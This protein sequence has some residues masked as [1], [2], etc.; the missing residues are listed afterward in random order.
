MR[1]ADADVLLGEGCALGWEERS[2][3]SLG[4]C[5]H[6]VEVTERGPESRAAYVVDVPTGETYLGELEDG[7]LVEFGPAEVVD[8]HRGRHEMGGIFDWVKK[9]FLPPPPL[10]PESRALVPAAPQPMIPSPEERKGLLAPIRKF[11][12][13]L[14][15]PSGAS[16]FEAFRPK[17]QLPVEAQESIPASY[18][19]PASMFS[20]FDPSAPGPLSRFAEHAG[21]IAV[22][23]VPGP[24]APFV[25]RAQEVF[26]PFQASPEP[27]PFEAAQARQQ[28]LWS[29]MFSEQAPVAEA[30]DIFKP[31]DKSEVVSYKQ[32]IRDFPVPKGYSHKDVKILRLPPRE[33]LFPEVEDVARGLLEFYDP[34]D[35]KLF[36]YIRDT[37][38]EDWW[39]GTVEED[40]ISVLHLES[41]GNCGDWPDVLTEVAAFLNIPWMALRSLAEVAEDEE[42]SEEWEDVS[43]VYDNIVYPA[44]DLIAKAANLLKPADLPGHFEVSWD[45]DHGCML[46][47]NYVETAPG[48]DRRR[49]EEHKHYPE[50]HGGGEEG[51][52]DEEIPEEEEPKPEPV[53]KPKKKKK[54]AGKKR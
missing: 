33:E 46:I 4:D 32:A 27:E 41:L 12:K 13:G 26:Q 1:L 19:P 14:K 28:E 16:M 15:P 23:S 7:S 51:Y 11:F 9:T 47:L 17:S 38:S 49:Y 35:K 52:D 20:T 39:K 31:F 24:L 10:P 5:V 37:R 21:T 40:G 2:S 44:A 6:L 48:F 8:V 45:E 22:P 36:D 34:I 53:K 54:R 25:E 3:L 18:I 50:G 42:G 30:A 43:L 29:G